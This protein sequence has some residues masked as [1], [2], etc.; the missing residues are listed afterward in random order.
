MGNYLRKQID[1]EDAIGPRNRYAKTTWPRRCRVCRT[2]HDLGECP[3]VHE[4]KRRMA[5][6]KAKCLSEREAAAFA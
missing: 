3:V 1:G 6:W 2:V 5:E 4:T